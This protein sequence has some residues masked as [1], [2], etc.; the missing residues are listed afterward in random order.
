MTTPRAYNRRHATWIEPAPQSDPL[1]KY[2]PPTVPP[3]AVKVQSIAIQLHELLYG[4]PLQPSALSDD[5]RELLERIEVA[6]GRVAVAL[7]RESR[8]KQ[9]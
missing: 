4:N 2:T 7:Y 1:N 5:K 8:E 6:L 3:E 9:A